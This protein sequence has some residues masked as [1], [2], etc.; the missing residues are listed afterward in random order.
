MFKALKYFINGSHEAAPFSV[1]EEI[2]LKMKKLCHFD[3]K[4]NILFNLRKEKTKGRKWKKHSVNG[5]FLAGKP[6]N[7]SATGRNCDIMDVHGC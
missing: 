1:K 3:K 7:R 2:L 5:G 4:I 6:P